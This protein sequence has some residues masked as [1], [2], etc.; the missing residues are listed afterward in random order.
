MQ[1]IECAAGDV[2]L[3]FAE[4]ECA[5][6]FGWGELFKVRRGGGQGVCVMCVSVCV[7]M[8]ARDWRLAHT[9]PVSP[10]STGPA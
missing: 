7:R 5:M 4:G 9:L 10:H 2:A 3:A 8:R 6:A 1:G